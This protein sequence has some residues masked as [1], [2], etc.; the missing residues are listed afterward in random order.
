ML[1]PETQIT[2]L[3]ALKWA[4]SLYND[5]SQQS[6]MPSP[7]TC[8]S[9]TSVYAERLSI[10]VN[11]YFLLQIHE[12]MP[13]KL[14]QTSV[15]NSVINAEKNRDAPPHLSRPARPAGFTGSRC[16]EDVNECGSSP[17]ANGGQ[18]RDQPGSFHCECLPGKLGLRHWRESGGPRQTSQA[19]EPAAVP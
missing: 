5:T 10:G 19:P 3:K 12:V 14:S 9:V 4:F 7:L 16:E 2:I 11:S 8:G 6:S 1:H 17:C 13:V 15:T 18:C